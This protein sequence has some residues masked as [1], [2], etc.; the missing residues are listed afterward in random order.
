MIRRKIGEHLLIEK[1]IIARIGNA[2]EENSLLPAV[3]R[4]RCAHRGIDVGNGRIILI[5]GGLIIIV[6]GRNTDHRLSFLIAESRVSF[7]GDVPEEND[8]FIRFAGD[9]IS[10][11]IQLYLGGLIRSGNQRIGFRKPGEQLVSDPV[12]A[13]LLEEIAHPVNHIVIVIGD[14]SRLTEEKGISGGAAENFLHP[15]AL[16]LHEGFDP[17]ENVEKQHRLND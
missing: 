10:A 1:H 15:F 17:V 6:Q 2:L 12:D 11:V 16:F 5:L 13:P 7:L 14:H 9:E 4:K 8:R 3:I